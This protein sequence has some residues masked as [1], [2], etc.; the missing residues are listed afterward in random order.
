MYKFFKETIPANELKGTVF[1]TG[2]GSK[3]NKPDIYEGGG[4]YA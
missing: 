2:I 4:Y 3:K 1:F